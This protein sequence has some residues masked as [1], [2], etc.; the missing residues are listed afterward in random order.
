MVNGW[1]PFYECHSQG[2]RC[3]G[4][5]EAAPQTPAQAAVRT[6]IE[7]HGQVDELMAQ[8]DIGQIRDP[9]LVGRSDVQVCRQVRIDRQAV[10][11]VGG[12]HEPFLSQTQQVVLAHE[13]QDPLV[14][15]PNALPMQLFCDA[16]IAIARPF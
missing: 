13:A 6:R 12:G 4:R 1:F 15:C 3:Q 7:H 16:P 11:A 14:V 10:V 8:T 5:V 2:C 9:E